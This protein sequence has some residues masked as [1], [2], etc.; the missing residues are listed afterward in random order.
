MPLSHCTEG[1]RRST[2][3]TSRIIAIVDDDLTA[4]G[5]RWNGSRDVEKLVSPYPVPSY[6]LLLIFPL[7]PASAR[8]VLCVRAVR[9][10]RVRIPVW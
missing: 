10:T 7:R 6:F 1:N 4:L 5:R 9:S 2:S 3:F 8:M